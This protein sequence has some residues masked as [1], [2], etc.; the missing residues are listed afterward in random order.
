MIK[1][2]AVV[3]LAVVS[4]V[5]CASKEEQL[6]SLKRENRVALDGLYARYGGGALAG[7]LKKET[8]KGVD[9]VR[10]QGGEGQETATA[11]LQMFGNAVGEVD[12]I[13][14]QEQCLGFGRGERPPV[15]NDKARAF[16]ADNANVSACESVGARQ[17]KVAALERELGLPP[18]TP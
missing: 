11:M 18:S 7:E 8:A 12:R 14:F 10:R 15:L 9:D 3:S 4:L 1:L 2:V 13:A 17:L 5:G 16:F 6:V